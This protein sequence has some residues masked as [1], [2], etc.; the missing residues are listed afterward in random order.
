MNTAK[1]SF[2]REGLVSYPER[3]GEE[4]DRYIDILRSP[5]ETPLTHEQKEEVYVFEDHLMDG[6]YTAPDGSRLEVAHT[7]KALS[8]LNEST[9]Y[10]DNKW[11]ITLDYFLTE[12]GQADLFDL[13]IM[14]DRAPDL[15]WVAY[16]IRQKALD[17]PKG[18]LEDLYKKSEKYMQNAVAEALAKGHAIADPARIVVFD[19]ATRLLERAKG[20]FGYRDFLSRVRTALRDAQND[21]Q[22]SPALQAEIMLANRYKRKINVGVA[23]LEPDLVHFW[24]QIECLPSPRRQIAKEAVTMIWP[25]IERLD[26]KEGS[27]T[28]GRLAVR[29]DRLREGTAMRDSRF[30]SVS[31]SLEQLFE[32]EARQAEADPDSARPEFTE[33]Q[34]GQLD[35]ITFDARQMQRFAKGFI[36]RIGKLSSHPESE[37]RRDQQWPPDGKWQV[38]IRD[39]INSMGFNDTE[40]AL[41]IPADFEREFT[42]INPPIGVASGTAHEIT[43]G[44]QA[45]N[46]R[47]KSTRLRFGRELKGNGVATLREAGAILSERTVQKRLFGRDRSDNPHYMNALKVIEQGG[48]EIDA[49]RAFYESYK[50]A[51]PGES[52][53]KAYKVAFTRVKRLARLYGGYNSQPL[54]YAETALLSAAIEKL[55]PKTRDIILSE[56]GLGI[57][58]MAQLHRFGLLEAK[59]EVFPVDEFIAYTTEAVRE[60]LEKQG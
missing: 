10:S 35:E 50:Q 11:E 20:Y 34:I 41:V 22:D 55:D 56:G 46:T 21:G 19:D 48:G 59:P 26:L 12:K 2:S 52:D 1:E 3:P 25:L 42:R 7:D 30:S 28:M 31:L 57:Q 13:G 15:E 36:S 33:E 23:G 37:Y 40:G 49:I 5:S 51:N 60:M 54:N 32:A 16:Q 39:D 44:F 43:H 14:A 47:F 4:L 6:H 29:L 27:A 38:P 17:F 45:S 53:K 24:N 8:K 18:A 9:K 58:D